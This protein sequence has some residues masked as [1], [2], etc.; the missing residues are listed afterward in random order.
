METIISKVQRKAKKKQIEVLCKFER[1]LSNQPDSPTADFKRR[2]FGKEQKGSPC[3][4]QKSGTKGT[5]FTQSVGK[6]RLGSAGW[7]QKS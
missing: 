7:V 4:G 6:F 1:P 3:V 5:R 2:A